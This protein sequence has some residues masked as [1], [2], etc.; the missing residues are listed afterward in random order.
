MI[1]TKDQCLIGIK[2]LKCIRLEDMIH[3]AQYIETYLDNSGPQ[4]AAHYKLGREKER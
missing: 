2:R 4:Q 1:T 3:V